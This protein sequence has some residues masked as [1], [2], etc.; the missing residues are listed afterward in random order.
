M[1]VQEDGSRVMTFQRTML[2]LPDRAEISSKADTTEK[3]ARKAEKRPHEKK[4][5]EKHSSSKKK[6][7]NNKATKK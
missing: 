5:D 1:S 6:K 3:Q 2:M 7:I 4:H